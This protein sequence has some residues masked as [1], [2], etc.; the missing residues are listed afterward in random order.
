M[1]TA[2]RSAKFIMHWGAAGGDAETAPLICALVWAE[3][4]GTTKCGWEKAGLENR[5]EN[6]AEEKW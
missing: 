3:R 6:F 2:N 5:G 4:R 1:E